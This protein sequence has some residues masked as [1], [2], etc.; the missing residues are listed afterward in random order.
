MAQNVR[1]IV[2]G[3]VQGVGFRYYA[4]Q[5]ARAL[6]VTGYVK[7]LTTGQVEVIAS[8]DEGQ[9]DDLIND[10]RVGPGHA[11]VSNVDLEKIDLDDTFNDFTIR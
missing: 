10:L 1:I 7:N 3:L 4:L 8:G 11:S 6:G 5:K 9:I 2:S